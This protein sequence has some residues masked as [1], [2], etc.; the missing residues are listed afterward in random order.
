MAAACL[1]GLTQTGL[2]GLALWPTTLF[3]LVLGISQAEASYLVIW[4][5]VAGIL[6][7][8]FMTSIIDVVGRRP[9]GILCCLLAMLA[10]AVAGQMAGVH[11]GT[12]SVFYIMILVTVFFGNSCTSPNS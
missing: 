10:A 9:S 8:V 5:S 7:R 12:A 11:I 2:A 1:T 3:V 4:V 6:G